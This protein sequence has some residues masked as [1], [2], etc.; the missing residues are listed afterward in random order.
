MSTRRPIERYA[1]P[2]VTDAR[3]ARQW[4]GT[5]ERIDRRGRARWQWPGLA[6]AAGA[7][8]LAVMVRTHEAGPIT[9]GALVESIG[10]Q[11]ITLADGSRVDLAAK[12]RLHVSALEPRRIELA[13]EQGS[14]VFDVRH[15]VGRR[16]AVQAG[17]FDVIDEGTRFQVVLAEEG[18]ISVI[19]ERG[20]VRIERRGSSEPAR[21]LSAGERWSAGPTEHVGSSPDAS[22]SVSAE[23]P[24]TPSS[25]APEAAVSAPLAPAPRPPSPSSKD[26]LEAAQRAQREGRLRDA[27]TA[28][29]RLRREFR[30]DARAGL[31]AFELGRL[32][33]GPLADPRGAAQ[34]FQDAID[35]SPR[36]P[37]RE[38][39]E[40][41]LV[42]AFDAAGDVKRC[43]SSRASYLSHYPNGL[44][45]TGISS[46]CSRSP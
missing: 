44:H 15:L 45:T 46:R 10:P 26:I 29:D 7:L 36:A 4:A 32:R 38:D 17:A 41:H 22:A 35:L 42:E 27:A 43:E 11:V 2:E 14:A 6:A 25:S 34:A 16:F 18:A 5:Q 19:V 30:G 9:V 31:A 8:L 39:A 21:F 28:Y 37:F 40:A 24:P 13:L 1:L 23:P 33:L 3:I 20:T 12:S